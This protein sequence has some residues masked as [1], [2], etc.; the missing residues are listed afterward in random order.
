M[1]TE[2]AP[3]PVTSHGPALP[4]S[5]TP[6]LLRRLTALVS[7]APDAARVTTTAPYTGLPLADL[8]VS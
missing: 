8:P 7:A 6:A 3:R 4:A 2:H 5:I 1:A